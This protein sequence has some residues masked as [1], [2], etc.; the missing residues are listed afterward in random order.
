MFKL[1][2]EQRAHFDDFIAALGLDRSLIRA[3]VLDTGI[4]PGPTY[5]SVHPGLESAYPPQ[6]ITVETVD[7]MKRYAGI[8][9]EMYD[10]GAIEKHRASLPFWPS[11]KVVTDLSSISRMDT[12]NVHDAYVSYLFGHSSETNS[13]RQI[14]NE[15]YFPCEVSVFVVETILIRSG[16]SLILAAEPGQIQIM[17]FVFG[18]V[19]IAP[20][21]KLIL[22]YAKSTTR[23]QR[24]VQPASTDDDTV[25]LASEISA[26]GEDGLPG[27]LGPD[28]AC[29]AAGGKGEPAIE[30]WFRC[31][32][33]AGQGL[34]GCPG[35]HGANGANG[36]NGYHSV[37]ASI[38]VDTVGGRIALSSRGGK[39]GAGGSGGSGG[40][41][42]SG[43]PGGCG[44]FH[45]P[46]GPHGSG[47]VGGTGGA[48]GNGGDS[49]DGA[50]IYFSYTHA[51]P[52]TVLSLGQT[53]SAPGIGG[54][55]GAG[56]AGGSGEPPGRPGS[57]GVVGRN[58]RRGCAGKVYLN[59][60]RLKSRLSI[61]PQ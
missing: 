59:G 7:D 46:H 26:I 33:P 48:G 2:K 31:D 29:G 60:K 11:G 35:Q 17:F 37:E 3:G 36:H 41:G 61:P 6:M 43:G 30:G 8:T 40:G 34:P 58:G 52:G 19:M 47:G 21:G 22:D 28:G 38:V 53:S 44:T 1:S 20:G 10:R 49:G 54:A 42:G 50:V 12:E 57:V 16:H 51:E 15:R 4:T 5:L 9:D 18:T 55:G 24:L 39:G 32:R 27:A 23:I 45:C 13:Y 25:L 56:G 14:I